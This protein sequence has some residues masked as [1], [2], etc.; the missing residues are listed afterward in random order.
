MTNQISND[1]AK[2]V[3]GQNDKIKPEEMQS[4]KNSFHNFTQRTYDYEA[5][6]QE[7]LNR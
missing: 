7:L 1:T 5:L 2:I 4:N 6:E 3:R